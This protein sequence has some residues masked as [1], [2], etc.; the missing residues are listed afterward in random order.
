M[1]ILCYDLTNFQK[2]PQNKAWYIFSNRH[3]KSAK[4]LQWPWSA[5][6]DL[7]NFAPLI[8]IGILT[9]SW[10]DRPRPLLPTSLCWTKNLKVEY[11]RHICM[12]VLIRQVQLFK[13]KYIGMYYVRTYILVNSYLF[14]FCL[15]S[16]LVLT[17]QGFWPKINC[18]QMKL[19][20]LKPKLKLS[21]NHFCK[22]LN[23]HSSTKKKSERLRRC[24]T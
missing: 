5:V 23:N 17:E 15:A 9:N 16:C 10:G 13:L 4:I 20:N 11:F 18:S 8:R 21:I 24:L 3:D 7:Y 22:T 1:R 14:T 12:H 2:I 19:P 6:V